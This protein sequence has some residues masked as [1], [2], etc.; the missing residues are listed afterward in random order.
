MTYYHAQGYQVRS[1]T[2]DGFLVV[3]EEMLPEDTD[4]GLFTKMYKV[5]VKNLRMKKYFLEIKHKAEGMINWRTRGQLSL[6][7]K[8]RAMTGY[9]NYHLSKEELVEKVKET[10]QTDEKS[11]TFVQQSL[12]S[13]SDL[14]KNGGDISMYYMEKTYSLLADNKRAFESTGVPAADCLSNAFQ[15]VEEARVNKTIGELGRSRYSKNAPFPSLKG[16]NK[17]EAYNKT[18]IRQ[19]IR[20]FFVENNQSIFGILVREN[21]QTIQKIVKLLG[22][23]VSLNYISQQKSHAFLP[24]SLP[25]TVL[26]RELM[27]RIKQIYPSLDDTRFF[28]R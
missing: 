23:S 22:F 3:A 17:K 8:I 14:I 15:T 28:V 19:L 26:T 27:D 16:G 11:F 25:E 5:A 7:G 24:A 10:L 4:F 20:A 6:D 18:L 2:T 21:R 1:C 12:R 9:S 13:G